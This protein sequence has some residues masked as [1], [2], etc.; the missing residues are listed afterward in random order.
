[1]LNLA[2]KS[3]NQQIILLK[4]ADNVG[5]AKVDI[6]AGTELP[7]EGIITRNH[8]PDGGFCYGVGAPEKRPGKREGPAG[9]LTLGRQGC[10]VFI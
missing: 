10:S 6:D 7:E 4:A 1:M 9:N 2:K 5:I 8:L 3:I